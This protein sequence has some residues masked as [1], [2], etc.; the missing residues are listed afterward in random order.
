MNNIIKL[1][2]VI[3]TLSMM[4]MGCNNNKKPSEGDKSPTGT[5]TPQEVKIA[6][7]GDSL[8]YGHAWHNESY[9]VYLQ[10][11]L[12]SDYKV[13]NF[14]INGVSI[15]GYGG[16]WNNYECRYLKQSELTRCIEYKPDIIFIMLG[17]NDANNWNSARTIYKDEYNAL[18][19]KLFDELGDI[20]IVI[21]TS[22]PT[23]DGNSFNIPSAKIT[24]DVVPLQ[25]EVADDYNLDII[26][27]NQY[28][29]DKKGDE[30]KKLY[31]DDGVHLSIEG[32]KYL[33]NYLADYIDNN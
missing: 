8:T 6:C 11:K 33:A 29:R 26:D 16:S 17:S 2:G 13:E 10:E 31:R 5:I 19:D 12:K 14:G 27:T 20:E 23:V 21:M 4:L 7:I 1:V 25:K 18:L 22:L 32:A 9:P 24:N 30:F 28:F 15:T 3:S